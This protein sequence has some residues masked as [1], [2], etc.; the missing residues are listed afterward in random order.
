[1]KSAHYEKIRRDVPDGS[2]A[3][4][5]QSSVEYGV[6]LEVGECDSE[7]ESERT[8]SIL[9]FAVPSRTS[10][11]CKGASMRRVERKQVLG[12][13]VNHTIARVPPE[14]FD[15]IFE[16]VE[17]PPD[18]HHQ[19]RSSLVSL[20]RSPSSTVITIGGDVYV[21]SR[22]SGKIVAPLLARTLSENEK[23][24]K[25]V[26]SLFSGTVQHLE[27]ESLTHAQIL[28]AS[29]NVAHVV[30][31]GYS[32]GRQGEI[33]AVL[34]SLKELRSLQVDMHHGT[35]DDS[36]SV[37]DDESLRTISAPG[38]CPRLHDFICKLTVRSAYQLRLLASMAPS[39][40]SFYAG[41]KKTD[42]GVRALSRDMV[43]I[44]H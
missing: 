33:R 34:A 20:C 2:V 30:I 6:H 1:M 43:L 22:R 15:Q 31:H 17:N 28:A 36:L 25:L 11:E 29:A 37:S 8:T 41:A 18:G 44:T 4:M 21:I 12:S 14:I 35:L 42:S 40:A 5:L 24:A 7:V 3:V 16:V 39:I 32:N 27:V 9:L 26:N 13:I 38:F 19:P 23:F 10:S